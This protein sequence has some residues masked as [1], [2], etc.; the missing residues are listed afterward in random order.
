[1]TPDVLPSPS[2][3]LLHSIVFESAVDAVIACDENGRV[4]DCNP[5][6]LALFACTREDFLG[7]TPI[8]W[9]PEYQPDGRASAEA[10]AETFARLEEGHPVRFDWRNVRR[11]GTPLDV[12]VTV[13]AARSRDSTIIVVITREISPASRLAAELRHAEARFATAFRDGVDPMMIVEAGTGIIRTVNP[14]FCQTFG[15]LEADCVGVTTLELGIWKHPEERAPLLATMLRDRRVLNYEIELNTR[16][17]PSL[18]ALSS[19]TSIEFEDKTY[20]LIQLRDITER[21]RTEA[22]LRESEA[23]LQFLIQHS[24]VP[25]LIATPP[26]EGRTL[27]LNHRFTELFGYVVADIPN[28]AAWWPRVYPDPDYRAAMQTRCDQAIVDA[29]IVMAHKLGLK[30]I[31]EGVE[32]PEQRDRL[33]TAGCDFAQGYLFARPLPEADFEAFTRARMRERVLEG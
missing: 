22:A 19:A 33:L 31:A 21:K 4:L 7:T 14:A 28:L 18:T 23:E 27:M 5:A 6:A 13:R 10:V 26:P 24:P 9:S 32:T 2:S 12:D 15:Y 11:D 8:D 17:G 16:A 30:V 25:T 29:I 20:W 3:V 1:M